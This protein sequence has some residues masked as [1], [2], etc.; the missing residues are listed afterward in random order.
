MLILLEKLRG[1]IEEVDGDLLRVEDGFVSIKVSQTDPARSSRKVNLILELDLVPGER[2]PEKTQRNFPKAELFLRV[3]VFQEIS[4]W[5]GPP[6]PA[7]A[8][9]LLRTFLSL[10]ML[11]SPE[12]HIKQLE[13]ATEKR[14]RY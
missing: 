7:A 9:K 1:F 3:A 2:V 13:M 12:Y 14:A 10:T 8:D 6:S 11:A 4:R 5:S